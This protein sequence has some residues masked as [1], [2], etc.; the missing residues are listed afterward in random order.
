MIQTNLPKEGFLGLRQNFGADISAGFVAFLLALPLS[1]G[2]AKASGFPASMGLVTAIIGGLVATFFAGSR[3]TIKGPAAGLIVIIAG[4]VAAFGGGETGW[5]LT[6]GVLVV[7]GLLQIAFGLLKWGR[8]INFFPLATVH[9]MLAAIGL[10][11]IAKQLPVLLNV[12]PTVYAGK[13]PITLLLSLPEYLTTLDPAIAVIGITSLGLMLIWPF[14]AKGFWRKLPAPLL[15]LLLAVPASIFLN[16]TTTAPDYTM[17]KAGSL[18]DQ[19]GIN[20]SFGGTSMLAVFVKYTLLIAVVGS[21]ESLLTV[22]AIDAIDPHKRKSDPNKD[23]VAIGIAN[24][25]AGILGGLPMISEVAR[26]SAS[27]ASGAQTRWANLWHG[28]FLLIAALA[29]YSVLELIPNAALAAMLIAVGIKLSH[30][31]VFVEAYQVGK[32]QLLVFIATV[33]VTLS[34]DLLLGILAGILVEAGIHLFKGA[35]LNTLFRSGATL[36]TT[37]EEVHL[38]LGEAACFSTYVKLSKMLDTIPTGKRLIINTSG[39]KLIDRSVRQNLND[40]I[41]EY[42]AGGGEVILKRT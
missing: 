16:L 23:L 8:M 3:L 17:L 40:F 36:K 10:I 30:P 37:K 42:K 29:A 27:V 1:L 6:L 34:Y 31:R 21:V 20:V 39:T 11:I 22:K 9:G 4:C 12:A 2:I 19:I 15:V 32:S 24:T 38:G 35:S 13:D 25:L 18:L 28:L 7:A 5:R 14:V 33:V 41:D 26:S